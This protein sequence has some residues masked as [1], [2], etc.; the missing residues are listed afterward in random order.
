[1]LFSAP[2]A[3]GVLPALGPAV[4]VAQPAP[5]SVPEPQA[6]GAEQD[7]PAAIGMADEAAAAGAPA[8]IDMTPRKPSGFWTSSQ[9][10]RGGAYRYRLLLIG[11]G[12]MLGTAVIMVHAIRRGAKE[13]VA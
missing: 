5:G 4:A 8:A 13:R 1:M 2:I 11:L 7:D 12:V 9:P 3:G 6:Q 10:A